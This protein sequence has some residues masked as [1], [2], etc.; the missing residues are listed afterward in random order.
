M[1]HSL[2]F[3]VPPIAPTNLTGSATGTTVNLSW[4]DNSSK[5]TGFTIQRATNDTF[6][7]G[8]VTSNVGPNVTGI[9]Q[10]VPSNT[11]Y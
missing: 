2:V 5:E 8:L 7:L 6:T 9:Q 10:T 11:T 4:N 1:M 3:A